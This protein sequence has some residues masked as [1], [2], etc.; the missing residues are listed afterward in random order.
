[1]AAKKALQ[2]GWVELPGGLYVSP[3]RMQYNGRSFRLSDAA[4]L[5]IEKFNRMA[6]KYGVQPIEKSVPP[7]DKFFKVSALLSIM[8]EDNSSVPDNAQYVGMALDAAVA[9]AKYDKLMK[10]GATDE[11]QRFK[12]LADFY[13][14][15]KS[16]SLDAVAEIL[17]FHEKLVGGNND[18]KYMATRYVFNRDGRLE[19]VDDAILIAPEGWTKAIGR[20]GY[21]TDTSKSECFIETIEDAGLSGKD[22]QGY[23]F[24]GSN[25]VGEQ[26]IVLRGPVWDG[27][28]LLNA[29][30]S[31]GHSYSIEDVGALRLRE[32]LP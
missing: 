9:K 12:P 2:Q 16:G 14:T 29:F 32:A 3:D 6:K 11:A 27:G 10:D 13:K 17:Q 4:N 22:L 28:R 26:R 25:P 31:E 18:G 1:M 7:I 24:V 19:P 21:P 15:L 20:R 23:W 8:Y 30:V 5:D